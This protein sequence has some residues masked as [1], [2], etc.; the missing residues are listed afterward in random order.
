[1]GTNS[2]N[3]YVAGLD[4]TLL[5]SGGDFPTGLTLDEVTGAP[6]VYLRDI[7]GTG[8]NDV[9]LAGWNGTLIHYDGKKVQNLVDSDGNPFTD[10]RL[11]GVWG[12]NRD[13]KVDGPPPAK[14]VLTTNAVHVFVVGVTGTFLRGP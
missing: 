3:F 14:A 6:K 9:F 13:A 7:W 5:R 2:S 4:G 8:M 12:F 10:Q 11:E 1:W